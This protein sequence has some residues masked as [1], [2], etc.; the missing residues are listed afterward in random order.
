M[1][2]LKLLFLLIFA[3]GCSAQNKLS[4]VPCQE[5]LN[6]EI[7]TGWKYDSIQAYYLADAKLL[8][9]IINNKYPCLWGKDTAFIIRTFGSHFKVR[10]TADNTPTR[11]IDSVYAEIS[12]PI[13]LPCEKA[14][15]KDEFATCV[16]FCFQFNR[17]GIIKKAKR[18]SSSLQV[19]H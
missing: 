1:T 11:F 9:D 19:K 12:Y 18:Q 15:G 16:S 13:T 8:N 14:L 10:A 5:N 6:N 2:P 17:Q 3:I 4:E 7:K